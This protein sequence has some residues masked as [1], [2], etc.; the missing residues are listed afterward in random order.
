MVNTGLPSR[1]CQTCRKRRVK[2]RIPR[3]RRRFVCEIELLKE[4]LV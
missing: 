3:Y 4:G 2:V 1:D